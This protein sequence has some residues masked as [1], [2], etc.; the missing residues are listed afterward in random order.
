MDG[1]FN[2]ST[3]AFLQENARLIAQSKEGSEKLRQLMAN[4]VRQKLRELGVQDEGAF[5]AWLE[6]Q[7]GG[8]DMADAERLAQEQLAQ[9]LAPPTLVHPS[10]LGRTRRVRQMV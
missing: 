3:E 7:I 1:N 4:P 8:T 2:P 9:L 5:F 10:L 6:K